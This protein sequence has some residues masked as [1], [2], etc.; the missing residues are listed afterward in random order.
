[1]KPPNPRHPALRKVKKRALYEMKL[2]S[3]AT[4]VEAADSDLFSRVKQ[5]GNFDTYQLQEAS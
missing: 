5:R 3:P 2:R 1:M 4:S